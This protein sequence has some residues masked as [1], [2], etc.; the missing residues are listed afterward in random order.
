MTSGTMIRPVAGPPRPYRFPAFEQHQISNGITVITV[1]VSKMPLVSVIA[2]LDAGAEKDPK[3]REGLAA[4][5]AKL[6]LEGTERLNGA[7]LVDAFERLGATVD[8]GAGWDTAIVQLTV[9]RTHVEEALSLLSE[10]LRTPAFHTN[11]VVRLKA[12]RQAGRL[13]VRTE[14]RELADE[15]FE[16]FLYA[17]A[18][19]YAY[20]EGGRT[21]S[22]DAISRDDIVGFYRGR[23]VPER[24]TLIMA[25]DI[26]HEQ[27]A[28]LATQV[29]G[30]WAGSAAD[31]PSFSDETRDAGRRVHIVAKEDA[32]QSE[33]RIGHRG[34]PRRHPDY[35]KLVVMN[36]VLGGLFTS[37]INLNLRERHG[38]AY[39]AHSSFEWRRG[40]GPFVVSTAVESGVTADATSEVIAEIEGMRAAPISQDELS[41]ATSYLAGVFPIR[42]ETTAAIA[43]ALTALATY[44]YPADYFDTYRDKITSVTVDDVHRMA[45]EYLHPDQLLV[46]AVG[47]PAVIDQPLA[48]LGAGPVTIAQADDMERYL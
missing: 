11:D 9:M 20:P 24:L 27:G 13:Q 28:A 1:P 47:D 23:Y 33:L 32:S 8:A 43:S 26:S 34:V 29:F 22:I 14:P 7:E 42:Y 17:P 31:P 21:A 3:E 18:S 37:R 6:L 44:S 12:E 40:S 4:L 10:V 19:R 5:T 36:A 16:R 48:A 38:Y 41:L 15:S 25:G 39:G 35:F 2:V 30:E 45:R 46:L